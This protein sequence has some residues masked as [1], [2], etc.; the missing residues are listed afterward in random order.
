ML[1]LKNKFKIL[2]IVDWK[3]LKD[4]IK[5]YI[6]NKRYKLGFKKRGRL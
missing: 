2:K 3:L 4:E 1:F 5:K 6:F